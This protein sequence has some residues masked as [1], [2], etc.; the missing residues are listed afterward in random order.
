M[1]HDQTMR[2]QLSMVF[3]IMFEIVKTAFKIA[4]TA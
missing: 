2:S 4:K 1:E 3:P